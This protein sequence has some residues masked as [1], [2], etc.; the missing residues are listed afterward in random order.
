MD[1]VFRERTTYC[2]CEGPEGFRVDGIF[3]LI[4]CC[5]DFIISSDNGFHF[6]TQ[7]NPG[8]CWAI[9]TMTEYLFSK[10]TYLPST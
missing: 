5:S 2:F 7:F 3:I 4:G 6:C 8:Y 1:E 10:F 9:F